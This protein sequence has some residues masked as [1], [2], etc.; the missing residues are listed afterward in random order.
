[1]NL[2]AT[3]KHELVQYTIRGVPVEVDRVLRKKAAQLKLSLNQVVIDELTRATIG[4]TRKA[5][6]SELVGQW[7]PDPAFDEVIASQRQI[8]WS[9]WK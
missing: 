3:V 6:F 5:D 9:K 2:Q 7:T 8:D 4:R 1:M